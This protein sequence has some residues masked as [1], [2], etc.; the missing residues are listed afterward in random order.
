MESTLISELMEEHRS[1]ERLLG[2]LLR[3]AAKADR[4]GADARSRVAAHVEQFRSFLDGF[5]HGRE[6][7]LL[8]VAMQDA[9]FPRTQGPLA[10]MLS[11]HEMGRSRVQALARLGSGT[12]PL[13]Q[14]ELVEL[15]EHASAFAAVLSAHIAKEDNVLYPMAL[16]RLGAPA[17]EKLELDAQRF[18]GAASTP[19]A[20]LLLRAAE[21]CVA[22]EEEH[23]IGGGA[24]S[25]AE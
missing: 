6:E 10:V 25:A 9:G 21:L 20:E 17:W 22:N 13:S 14:A 12:G 23:G 16:A 15:R 2:S 5:H 7:D 8:F 19:R 11:E 18:A 24:R 3:V 4:F 1:I